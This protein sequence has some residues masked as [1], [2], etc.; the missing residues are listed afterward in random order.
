[1]IIAL[2]AISFGI[3]RVH[4]KRAA[5]DAA[6]ENPVTPVAAIPTPPPPSP[7]VP[8]PV[9][10]QPEPKQTKPEPK[11]SPKPVLPGAT[12]AS[13]PEPVQP[14]A[15]VLE[16]SA[17]ERTNVVFETAGQPT[18]TLALLP[19]ESATL[20]AKKEA[21]LIV[22]NSAALA[23]RLNGKPLSFGGS[24]RAGEF[25]ITPAG[26]DESRSVTGPEAR[27]SLAQEAAAA[28]GTDEARG[29]GNKNT[30]GT[31]A[32]QRELAQTPTAARLLIES[33]A[34]PDF[35]TVIVRADN[36]VLFRRDATASPPEGFGQRRLLSS[37]VPTSPLAE[38]RL[39]PSG[40]HTLQVNILLGASKLGQAQEVSADFN[41][42]DRRKLLIQFTG[43]AR[44][45]ERGGGRYTVTL[46]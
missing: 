18:E 5:R 15:I 22:G 10:T 38:E 33:P 23:A 35:V 30:I 36:E 21:K 44:G 4:N 29:R 16:L 39:L 42:K 2:L 17:Q 9:D 7:I 26:I 13:K 37:G 11:I 24:R 45:G 34:V 6:T 1:M 3:V 32:R 31:A 41:G 25:V 27:A 20:R 19:G 8:Q 40:A 43:A 14:D 12:P 46:E 28:F